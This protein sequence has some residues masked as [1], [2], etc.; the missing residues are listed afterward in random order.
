V[1]VGVLERAA[2][3]PPGVTV[4][5]GESENQSRAGPSHSV[6]TA[7]PIPP[8]QNV[9]PMDSTNQSLTRPVTSSTPAR[10]ESPSRALRLRRRTCHPRI[11]IAVAQAAAA[12]AA[13]LTIIVSWST[14]R[15][16]LPSRES[17]R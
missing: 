8:A 2:G 13:T 10:T 6:M 3:S 12:M 11:T 15:P 1:A 4:E 17:A 7:A 14:S 5:A 16:E 9:P